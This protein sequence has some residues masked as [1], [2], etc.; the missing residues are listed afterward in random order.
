MEGNFHSSRGRTNEAI[1]AYMKASSFYGAKPYAEFGLGSSYYSLGETDA[2]LERFMS[3]ESAAS[4]D[5]EL[6]YRICYNQGIV[7]F[8][9][10]LFIEAAADFR[11][12]LNAEPSHIDAKR[13]L[14]LSLLSQKHQEVSR[15][16][17]SE[18]ETEKNAENNEWMQT[19]FKFVKEKEVEQWKSSEWIESVPVSGPDY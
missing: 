6:L 12:A 18:R 2:A 5:A 8:E 9:K 4:G 10:G 1:A 16:N 19:L 15:Q 14:E 13:S 3:A 11:R 7:K 17:S